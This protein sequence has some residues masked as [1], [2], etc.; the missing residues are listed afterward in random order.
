MAQAA[1]GWKVLIQVFGAESQAEARRMV[2]LEAKVPSMA[3]KHHVMAQAD[4]FAFQAQNV[5]EFMHEHARKLLEKQ[6]RGHFVELTLARR[7]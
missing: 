2:E 6:G 4:N 1:D 3:L 7:Y 5:D